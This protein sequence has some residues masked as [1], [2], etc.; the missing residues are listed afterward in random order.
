MWRSEVSFIVNLPEKPCQLL[1]GGNGDQSVPR[2]RTLT[3]FRQICLFP[4]H[5]RGRVHPMHSPPLA[6]H[7]LGR[8]VHYQHPRGISDTTLQSTNIQLDARI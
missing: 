5:P 7:A 3:V 6:N 2:E 1:I 4:N 8:R